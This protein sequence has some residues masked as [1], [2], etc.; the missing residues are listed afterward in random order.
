MK[1]ANMNARGILEIAKAAGQADIAPGTAILT[2]RHL[3]RLSYADFELEADYYLSV[4]EEKGK[5]RR[6]GISTQNLYGRMKRDNFTDKDLQ[7]I[8]EVLNCTFKAGFVLN[9]TGEEI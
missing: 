8:A 9:D 6:L 7:K 1:E 3:A 5:Y 2:G 4:M